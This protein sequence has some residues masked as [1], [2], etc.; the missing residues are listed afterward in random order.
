MTRAHMQIREDSR[1]LW[2]QHPA[3]EAAGWAK[4]GLGR[5]AQAGRPSPFWGPVSPP[6]T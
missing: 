2:N 3:K 4:V 5:P 1:R 6:L